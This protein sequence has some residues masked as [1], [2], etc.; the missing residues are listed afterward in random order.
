[1]PRRRADGTLREKY[2]LPPNV[3]GKHWNKDAVTFYNIFCRD[4]WDPDVFP[5]PFTIPRKDFVVFGIARGRIKRVP[6]SVSADLRRALT[7]EQTQDC[8]A[9]RLGINK[10]T[11][12]KSLQ[13]VLD[14]PYQIVKHLIGSTYQVQT[15]ETRVADGVDAEA[16][17]G[18][19]KA[20]KKQ[21]QRCYSA[22]KPEK[23]TAQEME[24]LYAKSEFDDL[25]F[26]DIDQAVEDMKKR[27]EASVAVRRL[28]QWA[29]RDE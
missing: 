25:L 18:F 23:H 27:I 15:V 29:G 12:N 14:W 19:A 1:M 26:D 7:I 2:G 21:V 22:I 5:L 10:A 6:K 8:T 17:V 28:E 11:L 13:H 24:D 4:R 9:M 16:V 3:L 20:K